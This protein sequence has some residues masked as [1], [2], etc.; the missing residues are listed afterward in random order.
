MHA[1]CSSKDF[2]SSN[3]MIMSVAYVL[4]ACV[5]G[6]GMLP[7]LG[8]YHTVLNQTRDRLMRVNP[9]GRYRGIYARFIVRSFIPFHSLFRQ[10]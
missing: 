5:S 3:E 7:A 6:T 4:A 1:I 9:W 8:S 10:P 2:G